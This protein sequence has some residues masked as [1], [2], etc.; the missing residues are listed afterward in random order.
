MSASVRAAVNSA[1]QHG[2]PVVHTIEPGY[3]APVN[4]IRRKRLATCL[5]CLLLFM[6][7][8]ASA[9]ACMLGEDA[10]SAGPSSAEAALAAD[11]IPCHAPQPEPEPSNLCK[12]HCAQSA[13]SVDTRAQVK[14]DV[15]PV[16]ALLPAMPV[17]PPR[18][19]H[20]VSAV[21]ARPS[22]PGHPPLYLDHCRFL[23]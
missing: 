15:P 8:A 7:V 22:P 11:E 5:V 14:I 4:R 3:S 17:P 23:I 21:L 9:Y 18:L 10:A 13:Q 12:A 6:Q 19:G 16:P 1:A 20:A 2:W